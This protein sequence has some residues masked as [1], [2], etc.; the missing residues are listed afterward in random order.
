[1]SSHPARARRPGGWRLVRVSVGG[2]SDVYEEPAP[3]PIRRSAPPP[4]NFTSHPQRSSHLE[5]LP[6]E[7]VF[8]AGC[9]QHLHQQLALLQPLQPGPIDEVKLCFLGC[10][11]CGRLGDG[12]AAYQ[13]ASRP[14]QHTTAPSTKHSRTLPTAP[15]QT[16]VNPLTAPPLAPPP[17]PPAAAWPLAP[18]PIRS[19]S[20]PPANLATSA[21][22]PAA[23]LPPPGLIP[24]RLAPAARRAGGRAAGWG[25][26]GWGA[27]GGACGVGLLGWSGWTQV[28]ALGFCRSSCRCAPAPS[29][30]RISHKTAIPL[31]ILHPTQPYHPPDHCRPIHPA[32]V[33]VRPPV[34]VRVHQLQA[35]R[36][37]KRQLQHCQLDA[38]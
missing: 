3:L 17:P 25:G 13:H 7:Q 34:D 5:L 6:F 8:G 33:K 14:P 31:A 36:G 24:L 11:C 20:T 4:E 38:L 18:P 9:V 35:P 32:Y 23:P 28:V 30:Q 16:D 2:C 1:V 22:T 15:T 37:A 27:G 12:V 19:P 26:A 21:A 29:P 10:V